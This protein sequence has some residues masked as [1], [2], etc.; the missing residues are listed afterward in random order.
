MGPGGVHLYLRKDDEF[1]GFL[2]DLLSTHLKAK[3]RK[4]GH[5][6]KKDEFTLDGKWKQWHWEG[7]EGGGLEGGCRGPGHPPL[8]HGG[9]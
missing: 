3:P 1:R 7:G 4:S 2:Q 8:L 6:Q 9:L 5:V